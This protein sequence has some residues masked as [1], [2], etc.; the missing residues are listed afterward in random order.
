MEIKSDD[1][2]LIG[3]IVD[4]IPEIAH[5]EAEK[6]SKIFPNAE[7]CIKNL[8]FDYPFNKTIIDKLNEI[9]GIT[10]SSNLYSIVSDLK[11]LWFQLVDKS[12]RCL[13]FFDSREPYLEY[14]GKAPQSYGID[15][16]AKYYDEFSDFEALLYGSNQFYR[17][18]VIHLFRTWLIG[19]NILIH[20]EA[21]ELFYEIIQ[22]EGVDIEE[23]KSNFFEC[24]SIW[25]LAALCHDLGYPLEKFQGVLSKTQKMME[26]LV[27]QPK[28]QQD[29]AF[30][31]TQDKIN[32]YIVRMM[33]SKM[34]SSES[35]KGE[36]SYYARVQSKYYVKY[37]K[38]LENYSH[39]IVSS[40]IIYRALLYFLES[41]FSFHDDHKF[42]DNDAKQFYTRRDIL[43]SIS[44][45]TC[46]DIYHMRSNTFPLLLI[47]SDELQEWG[48]KKW[49][50]LYRNETMPDPQ[51]TLASY[52]KKYIVIEY[53]FKKTRKKQ[54]E[55][56]ISS[57]YSQ[58]KK[59][60]MLLRDGEDTST[61]DFTL[62]IRYNIQLY[63]TP[64]KNINISS[65]IP[66]KEA[67]TFDVKGKGFVK[68]G[69]FLK[70]VGGF[71][72]EKEIVDTEDF[73]ITL[74]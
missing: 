18:H 15:R 31:G 19:L 35:E 68:K 28:I 3:N 47:I 24:I 61:R 6:I 7:D 58:F 25:T 1:S 4:H 52:D 63:R 2:S 42:D 37:S 55:K 60:R 66:S 17:D 48:R 5:V 13:R 38:S 57:F 36:K 29:I 9:K 41:D 53:K 45:H 73:S 14:K 27:S 39:G 11:D 10:S 21:G 67:A 30:S 43:R 64:N 20:D 54:A 23:F 62:H 46:W 70:V 51:F 74:S 44:S 71:Y 33:S 12:I 26:Y 65:S 72:S 50:D 8:S 22:F 56:F 49:N 34:K 69:D 40:L 16:L 32:D 59:F